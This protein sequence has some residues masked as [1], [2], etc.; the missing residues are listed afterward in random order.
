MPKQTALKKP[1]VRDTV[2]L[3][4]DRAIKKL[5]AFYQRGRKSLDDNPPPLSKKQKAKLRRQG[6]S[7]DAFHKARALA[8][9]Y[10][11]AQFAKVIKQC[12][13]QNYP[14]SR[15]T[16]T[17]LLPLQPAD[18]E[19]YLNQAIKGNWSSHRLQDELLQQFGKH[20]IGAGRKIKPPADANRAIGLIR[21]F[22]ERWRRVYAAFCDSQASSIPEGLSTSLAKVDRAVGNLL[23]IT[24]DSVRGDVIDDAGDLVVEITPRH[25]AAPDGKIPLRIET[26]DYSADF[27]NGRLVTLQRGRAKT[28]RM[29]GVLQKW[30]G[31]KVGN[32]TIVRRVRF[33]R[34]A[35]GWSMAALKPNQHA[36]QPRSKG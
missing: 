11:A 27:K 36:R 16:L 28:N 20:R 7:L 8:G 25:P 29:E 3:A 5:N 15:Q 13:E 19:E 9:A 31:K 2:S 12:K 30:F 24:G 32:A 23:H 10:T 26:V 21:N 4:V 6:K 17:N 35:S 33:F 1:P 14:I 18:R 22:G 34:D